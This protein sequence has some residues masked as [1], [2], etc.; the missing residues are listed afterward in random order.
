ML[1][2]GDNLMAHRKVT[3]GRDEL[4]AKLAGI[5]GIRA[6]IVFDGRRGEAASDIGSN[7]RVVVTYGGEDET[8]EDRETADEWIGRE[9]DGVPHRALVEVVTAD[10]NLRRLAHASKVKTINPS[11]FWR[12][13]LPRIKGEKNDYRNAPRA[14]LEDA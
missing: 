12:R 9:L 7:P 8:G 2:D 1:I 10:R 6:I 5:R 3:K 4:A 11:K 14:D 13:Y